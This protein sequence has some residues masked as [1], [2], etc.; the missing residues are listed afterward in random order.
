MLPW[1]AFFLV[2]FA[3]RGSQACPAALEEALQGSLF[4]VDAAWHRRPKVAH[5]FE[6]EA[7]ELAR[8]SS[9]HGE[10]RGHLLV[11]GQKIYEGIRT[12]MIIIKLQ[13]KANI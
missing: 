11:R 10:G 12:A 1:G 7:L 6:E 3:G 5:A 4:L 9:R 13:V 8:A 2:V